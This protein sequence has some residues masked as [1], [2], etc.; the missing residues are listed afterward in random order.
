MS[1]LYRELWVWR[2]ACWVSLAWVLC[3]VVGV[4][5]SLPRLPVQLASLVAGGLLGVELL[6]WRLDRQEGR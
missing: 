2:L 4:T 6:Q 5:I 1:A 3:L